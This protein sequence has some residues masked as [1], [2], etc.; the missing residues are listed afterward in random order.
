MLPG[1]NCSLYAQKETDGYRWSGVA[2]GMDNTPRGREDYDSI[3]WFDL[4][5]QQA[6]AARRI[7]TY[8]TGPLTLP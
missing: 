6:L 2:S 5:A 3:L 1:T 4:L 8:A 7:A